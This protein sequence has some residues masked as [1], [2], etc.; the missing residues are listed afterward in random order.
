MFGQL[1]EIE[2]TKITRR[3]DV[4]FTL[5]YGDF[6]YASACLRV[7]VAARPSTTEFQHCGPVAASP[8]F[9]S[10]VL[11]NTTWAETEKRAQ[12]LTTLFAEVFFVF[13]C[14]AVLSLEVTACD[15]L[16][17]RCTMNARTELYR[18]RGVA[19]VSRPGALVRLP[20]SVRAV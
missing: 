8:P 3:C 16:R 15:R 11:A 12:R 19:R 14:W 10:R 2:E 13:G 6:V 18:R 20:S 5:S 7:R 9:L 1:R 17:R 4:F